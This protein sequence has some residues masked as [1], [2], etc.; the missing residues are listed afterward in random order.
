MKQESREGQLW[1]L[2]LA[3]GDGTRVRSFLSQLCSNRGIKQFCAIVGHRTM[4]AHTLARAEMLIPRQ[5]ILIVVSADHQPEIAQHL[6]HWPKENVIVQPANRDT[7][8]GILLPLAHIARRDPHALVTVFPSDHFIANEQ[9]FITSVKLAI[10]ET[11][12]F[13]E[14]FVLLGM[15][16]D[17]LENGYGWIEPVSEKSDRFTQSV[18]RFWEKP[19]WSQAQI[20]WQKGALW[21]SFVCVTYCRTLWEMVR[22]A[23]PDIYLHFLE[24][25]QALGTPAAQRV[26]KRIYNCL[27]AINFSSGVCEPWAPM[28]R[29]LP[30]PDVGWSDWGSVDRI[31][32]TVEQLG[33]KN[34][35]LA[36]LNRSEPK[37]VQ[38][39]ICIAV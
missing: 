21:N 8:A 24:I 27:R 36:R 33:K 16:P 37:A 34:E 23:V 35:L 12:L 39:E 9:G 28:L 4:L 11:R 5:R 14:S 25:Y 38:T 15:K 7:T 10:E 31:V 26:T 32:A 20:L 19:L 6:A 18:A 22:L 3:A 13:P 2:V 17:R 29:V 1:G 30:V